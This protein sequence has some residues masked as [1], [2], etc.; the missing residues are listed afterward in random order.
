MW[1]ATASTPGWNAVELGPKR[2]VLAELY[3]ATQAAGIDWGIYF[4]QGEW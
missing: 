4:S 1:N 2:D 3:E